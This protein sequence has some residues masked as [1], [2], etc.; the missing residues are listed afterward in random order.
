LNILP[1]LAALCRNV[2]PILRGEG[3]YNS[4]KIIPSDMTGLIEVNH[5]SFRYGDYGKLILQNLSF[6]VEEGKSL[7]LIGPSGCGKSTLLKALLGFY[8]LAGGKIYYGG[9]DLDTIELR[10]LRRQMGIVLQNG[11][12]PAGAIFD[13]LTD[14]DPCVPIENVVSAL[15]KVEIAAEIE[16]LPQGLYTPIEDCDL[17]DGQCQR[18]MIARALIKEHRFIFFD[19]PT[20]RLDNI[21]QM[22][23]LEHIYRAKATKIIVAQRLST[24]KGCDRIMILGKGTIIEQG[25]YEE[26]MDSPDILNWLS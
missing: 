7:G 8:P 4:R 9:Y 11:V 16:A 23:I 10:Y 22:R 17:S 14:N 3:E 21:S 15:E 25:S 20:S 18:I 24:V 6:Q 19:E 1:E 13:I 2:S 12:I 26:I 5:L